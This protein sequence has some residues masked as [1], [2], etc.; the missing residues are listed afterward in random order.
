MVPG[1]PGCPP[2]ARSGP[3]LS[4]RLA[5]AG[6]ILASLVQ[7]AFTAFE[8]TMKTQEQNRTQGQGGTGGR[9]APP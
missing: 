5:D 7:D 8:Q 1:L 2:R 4:A 9:T 3:G 6:G